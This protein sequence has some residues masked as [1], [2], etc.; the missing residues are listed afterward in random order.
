MF[1]DKEFSTGSNAS[2]ATLVRYV[3]HPGTKADR[4]G[5]RR[6]IKRNAAR[7]VRNHVAT[8]LA[9]LDRDAAGWVDMELADYDTAMAV[10]E[11]DER[12]TGFETGDWADDDPNWDDDSWNDCSVCGGPCEMD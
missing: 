6:S 8:E 7:M 12:I 9:E 2:T 1:I 11:R 4:A 10:I 3:D 5:M